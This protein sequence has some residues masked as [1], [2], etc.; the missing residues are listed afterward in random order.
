[1]MTQ[2]NI[3]VSLPAVTAL[4]EEIRRC[5][6]EFTRRTQRVDHL[7]HNIV[8]LWATL[9]LEPS[10][11]QDHLIEQLYRQV[12]IDDK[13]PL[14]N[15]LVSDKGLQAITQLFKRLEDTKQECEFRKQE[16]IQSLYQM[17]ERLRI[18]HQERD[19][20]LKNSQGLTTVDM[21]MLEEEQRRLIKLKE[22]RVGDFINATREELAC[23]WDQ[24]YMSDTERRMF[25]P[26]FTDEHDENALEA[27][28]NEVARLQ[29]LVEDRKHIL[30]K[31]EQHM[32]ILQE[33]KDFESTTN[34]PSRLFGKGQ[35]DPGRLLREEKFRKRVHRELPK[36][37]K[38]LKGALNEFETTTKRAFNVYGEPYLKVLEN[39]DKRNN[40]LRDD[41]DPKTPRRT[42]EEA[43]N[44]QQIVSPV[45]QSPTTRSIFR[46]PQPTRTQATT[47]S[48]RKLRRQLSAQTQTSGESILHRVR[49]NNIK[50]Q[51]QKTS[52]NK[53]KRSNTELSSSGN[54]Q[55]MSELDINCKEE[56]T[57]S[58]ELD[59]PIRKLRVSLS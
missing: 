49:E 56:S 57:L 29:L 22:E 33:I 21:K 36:I 6:N 20:L 47:A 51:Q 12:R 19:L 54:S 27:H 52:P 18:D 24:L 42:N 40:E 43:F 10:G 7:V 35:R 5:E 1:M 39:R 17:W 8:L 58:F 59:R 15:Q 31:V 25:G 34:D 26:A 16:I 14:Y 23:L 4:E 55:E 46:T 2:E 32:N 11:D 45:R 13:I 48:P 53:R 30:E 41:N 37:E 3:D 9:G 50:E 28:E 44:R 38:E